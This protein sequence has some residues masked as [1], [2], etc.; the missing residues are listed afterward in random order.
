M[1]KLLLVSILAIATAATGYS[2]CTELFFSE[3]IEGSS[4]NKAIE[5]FNPTGSAVDLSNYSV[6]EIINGG[7]GSTPTNTF[8]LYGM[9]DAYSV[10]VLATDQADSVVL[11][12]ADTALS[13]PS[14][15]HFNGDD[16]VVLLKGTDTID[17]IG[18]RWVDPGSAW[19]VDTGETKEY[20]LVR[21]MAV[22]A[23]QLDWAVGDDE[24]DVYPQNTFT[25][26]GMH[27][28]ECRDKTLV[29]EIAL[30]ATVYPNPSNGWINIEAINNIES[31]QVTD[32]L[33]NIV[34]E[35]SDIHAYTTE[36]NLTNV[37][38]GMY[39]VR[40]NGEHTST[41]KRVVVQ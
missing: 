40:I 27:K 24:W 23:G 31:V 41:V 7:G 25:M 11:S 38:A 18:E 13:Y 19:S 15:C 37:N 35:L 9:L 36:I 30:E 8:Q 26:L 28:S 22:V 5:I 21:K 4:N 33:G 6:L 34:A 14:V 12:V 16:G 10:F 29:Q 3:Y 39:F 2:Q 20:T 17:A 1:K 32:A